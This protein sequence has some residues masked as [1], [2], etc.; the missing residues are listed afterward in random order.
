MRIHPD[1]DPGHMLKNTNFPK[2]KNKGTLNYLYT[3]PITLLFILFR[4]KYLSFFCVTVFPPFYIFSELLD[5]EPDPHDTGND[6]I[7]KNG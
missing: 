5:P 4:T 7:F 3:G 1:P 2:A 6:D